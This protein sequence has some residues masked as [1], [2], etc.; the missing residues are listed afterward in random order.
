LSTNRQALRKPARVI[1]CLLETITHSAGHTVGIVATVEVLEANITTLWVRPATPR[2]A[3]RSVN[4]RIC[5]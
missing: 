1:C 2:T 3:A 5:P 4:V